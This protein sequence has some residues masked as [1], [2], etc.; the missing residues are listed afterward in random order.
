MIEMA[1]A[2]G[3]Q[4]NSGTAYLLVY[5]KCRKCVFKACEKKGLPWEHYQSLFFPD[6]S[7]W[8]EMFAVSLEDLD[9][10]FGCSLAALWRI[11]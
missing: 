3:L 2:Y 8:K 6:I 7:F 11:M 4:E 9:R 10:A 5:R 1:A